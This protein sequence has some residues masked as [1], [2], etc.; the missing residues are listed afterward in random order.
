M[1]YKFDSE[2][3]RHDLKYMRLISRD[4]SLDDVAL[5]SGVSKPT[6]SRAEKGNKIEI[7]TFLSLCGWM[8]VSPCDY[9][10]NEE[11]K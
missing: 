6:I 11:K 10:K 9:I 5:Q 1:E 2:R 8:G 3:F 7:S 4:L